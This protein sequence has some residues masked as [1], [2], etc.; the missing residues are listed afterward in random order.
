[1]YSHVPRSPRWLLRVALPA[2]RDT[3][4]PKSAS[5][6]S[7]VG[8]RGVGAV[9]MTLSGFTSPWMTPPLCRKRSAAA[10]SASHCK[11]AS[12]SATACGASGASTS[13]RML[14]A[15]R[16]M[17]TKYRVA[18]PAASRR[19]AAPSTDTMLGHREV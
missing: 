17:T 16:S 9:S 10:T 18:R 1:M 8:M 13:E 11:R 15:M 7:S 19:M 14:P 2:P 4:C 5:L 12:T 3:A 6:A